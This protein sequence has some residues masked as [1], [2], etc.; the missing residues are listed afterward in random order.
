M[1][2]LSRDEFRAAVFARD[3]SKC[4]L[5][6]EP[7]ADAHHVIERRLWPDGGYY[8]DNGASVCPACHIQCE[9]TVITVEQVREAAGI[10]KP[11]L[12]PHLYDDAI[13]DKWGNEIL[14]NGNR[15]RGELFDDTSVQRILTPVLHL[16]THYVKYP[17]T[18]HLP[19]SDGM[20][21]DDRQMPS[22][23]HFIGQQVVVTEK[24][25]GE[26]TTMYRDHVHARSVD[27]R[28]HP[29]RT[30]VKNFWSGLAH[31]I[32][33]GWRICGENLY[34]KHS[35]L[36]PDLPSYFMGFSIWS[37]VNECLS[38]DA[39][40]EA[41]TLFGITPVPVLYV[42]E[43]NEA[44]I[45]G[46]Y[47]SRTDWESREGYVVRLASHFHYS[48]FRF[49]VG[50]FVREKHVQTTRHWQ[51]GTATEKNVLAKT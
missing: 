35:I 17:R 40:V 27:G 9:Q 5:C 1:T 20:N 23:E 44:V 11:H 18:Y 22:I 34:A 21:E 33:E 50:K 25:D 41:F 30:W 2:L 48:Q 3:R 8:V 28:S 51:H 16:F 6:G 37:D 12:P 14:A 39:T 36:Y 49:S 15:V 4:V 13:Y 31:E 29:S 47:E 38:W 43:F 26:N 45:R 7:T 10:K 46:L 32:P 42:G 19:W 24:M